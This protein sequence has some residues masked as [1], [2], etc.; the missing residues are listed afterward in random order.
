MGMFR[1]IELEYPEHNYYYMKSNIMPKHSLCI[2]LSKNAI[3]IIRF[4]I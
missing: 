4:K 1:N 2:K 3:D